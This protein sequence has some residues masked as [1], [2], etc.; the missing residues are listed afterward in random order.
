MFDEAAS[1]GAANREK[2]GQMRPA[3]PII[4]TLGKM[5]SLKLDDAREQARNYSN[6]SRLGI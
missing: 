5:E 1:R 6:L 2:N 4:I 3:D